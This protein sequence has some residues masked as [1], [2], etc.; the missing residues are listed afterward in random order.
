M[1]LFANINFPVNRTDFVAENDFVFFLLFLLL[2]LGK[3]LYFGTFDINIR[4]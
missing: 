3:D 4:K 2:F 1:K